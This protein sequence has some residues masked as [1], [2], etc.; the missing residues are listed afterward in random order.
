MDDARRPVVSSLWLSKGSKLVLLGW[1]FEAR[2]EVRAAAF[3]GQSGSA[4]HRMPLYLSLPLRVGQNSRQRAK[5]I[6]EMSMSQ[7]VKLDTGLGQLI[8]SHNGT[9]LFEMPK[10]DNFDDNPH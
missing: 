7:I 3:D 8:R 5:T 1:S 4:S 6:I 2:L 10:M 9:V